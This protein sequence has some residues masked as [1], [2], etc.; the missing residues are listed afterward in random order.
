MADE[1]ASPATDSGRAATVT[2]GYTDD[3]RQRWLGEQHS[4]RRSDFA[5]DR[6]RL[7]HSSALRRLA[8]KTQ[9]LSPTA[10]I[11][12]ARNRLTHSLEVAQV[13][14][15]LATSLGL[16]PDVVDTACLA[17]DIGHPPF[18]HNGERALNAWAERIGGFE[19]NAQ[20]L[21]LLTRLEPKVFGPDGRTYGVN[22]TR[23]SLDA[24]CKY[25]WPASHSVADPSGRAKFGF[26][27]D[28]EAAF[29][30]LRAGAPERVRC[31]EAQVMDLSDDIAY[32]VHDFEDAVVGGYIDVTA[33]GSR[34][35]HGDLVDSMYE[36]IGGEF[37]HDALIAAFDRLAAM[38]VWLTEWDAGRRTQARL[39]DLT[40]QLI[41]RFAGA[42]TRATRQAYP[43]ECLTRF[44]ASVVVPEEIRAEIAVLKGI[45][46]T[47]VMSRN[48]RQPIY[49][50]QRDVL[51]GLADVL[52]ARGADALDA[53]FAEDWDAANDDEGRRRVVVDQVA[54]LTDQSALAW[55]DRL[56][57]G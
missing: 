29:R 8:A 47:F 25:P 41:G 3:D 20:T 30:W 7:L 37:D 13:G 36:W 56:V 28:D 34:I 39:K 31:I 38:T 21:R 6:A 22:L 35:D 24:S 2:A 17:H 18:G 57:R 40:S 5:R 52:Y 15:E 27:A 1:A 14:R 53:G 26:Y 23:A 48:T 44:A 49:A 50:E 16:D 46:A 54:S 19:G 9:V 42:A 4:S 51:T 11:D 43:H 45:V 12:F 10:G 32:S 55:Y 33:L